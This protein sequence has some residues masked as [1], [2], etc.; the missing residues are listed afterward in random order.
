MQR[1]KTVE[2][3]TKFIFFSFMVT[4]AATTIG[5]GVGEFIDD[6]KIYKNNID[7]YAI[8]YPDGYLDNIPVI[9]FVSGAGTPTPDDVSSKYNG[10]LRYVA[11]QGYY[12]IATPYQD[13]Y[14]A[15]LSIISLENSLVTS[16]QNHPELD[17]SSLGV[18]GHS[19][20]GGQAFPVIK[21]FLD[22][23]QNYGEKASFVLSIDG[24]FPFGMQEDDLKALH[25]TASIIQFGGEIGTGT[26]PRI[27]LTT[28]NLLP[29]SN[30][31]SYHVLGDATDH[32]YLTGDLNSIL[33]KQDLLEPIQSLLDYTFAEGNSDFLASYTNTITEVLG[34]VENHDYWDSCLGGGYGAKSILDKYNNDIIYC[35]P[36]S[37]A[38]PNPT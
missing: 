33:G 31:K 32:S 11:S 15:N 34:A 14:Y 19:V 30:K 6:V 28:M 18:M 4:Y 23:N 21:H 2:R 16:R 5:A 29:H 22:S 3:V 17:F 20:G 27:S 10:L 9:L 7:K 36:E 1:W 8:F 35:D 24:W 38:N 37:Y 13:S 12:V 26:D 25:T